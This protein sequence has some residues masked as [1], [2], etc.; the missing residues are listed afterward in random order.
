MCPR[1]KRPAAGA[2]A[3]STP[4]PT[5]LSAAPQIP[6]GSYELRIL[7]SLRQMIR[8]IEIHSRKLTQTCQI[9]G[10]QLSCLLALREHGELTTTTL[11]NTLYLSPSTVVG[12]V[13]RLEEKGLVSRRR[14]N[15]DRRQVQIAI[16]AAG[17]ELTSST[18]SP[19]QETLVESLRAL[20]ESEQIAITQ[21]LEKVVD[22]MQARKIDAAPMLETGPIFMAPAKKPPTPDAP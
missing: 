13:D 16:T 3:V 19:L 18:P 10:P 6:S 8:A 14:S 17:R 2:D 15:Q 4:R 12:I 20:P 1:E 11:A 22:L 9:T 5:S 21:A 7:Q